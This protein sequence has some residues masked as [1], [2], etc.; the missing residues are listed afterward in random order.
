MANHSTFISTATP[1][2]SRPR[3]PASPTSH[4]ESADEVLTLVRKKAQH[5][6]QFYNSMVLPNGDL[7]QTRYQT[8][9]RSD[10]KRHSGSPDKRESNTSTSSVWSQPTTPV[11]SSS[12]YGGV[13][14]KPRPTTSAKKSI[15]SDIRLSYTLPYRHDEK[16][17]SSSLRSKS[18]SGENFS[19]T[20]PP[21]STSSS[22]SSSD[23]TLL[24]SDF[25]SANDIKQKD[26]LSDEK[27]AASKLNSNKNEYSKNAIRPD[28]PRMHSHLYQV[29]S[30]NKKLNS[31]SNEDKSPTMS[32]SYT[33]P[34]IRHRDE[35][36]A[37]DHSIGEKQTPK[38]QNAPS[39][40][41]QRSNSDARAG[42]RITTNLLS[43]SYD[44]ITD[45]TT[46]G[47]QAGRNYGS[48]SSLDKV[49]ITHENGYS[50]KAR[51]K[52]VYHS[53]P[54]SSLPSSTKHQIKKH[55]SDSKKISPVNSAGSS[56]RTQRRRKEKLRS[57]SDVPDHTVL[58][59]SIKSLERDYSVRQELSFEDEH[60][61]RHR[62]AHYDW[63]SMLF[64]FR[65]VLKAADT[66]K[67]KN[68]TTGASKAAAL[69]ASSDSLGSK[70]SSVGGSSE[71]LSFEQD[72]H[73]DDKSNDMVECCP[74]FSNEVGGE[75]DR[76][77]TIS[78]YGLNSNSHLANVSVQVCNDSE[79]T[80]TQAR[81][82]LTNHTYL[83]IVERGSSESLL[84]PKSPPSGCVS[85]GIEHVDDGAEY[86]RTYFYEKDHQN[87]CG[88]DEKYGPIVISLRREK[89]DETLA[90]SSN[91]VYQ[92]RVIIRTCE[93]CTLRGS[94]V[95]DVVFPSTSKPTKGFH[96]KEVLEYLCPEINLSCLKVAMPIP[97]V[98]DQIM[99]VDEQNVHDSYK[100]GV[101]YCGAGQVTEE[102][103][104]NNEH[105]SPAFDQ[106]LELLGDKIKLSGFNRFRGGLD[107]KTDSTGTE[108]VYTEFRGNKILFHVST[109]LPFTPNNRQQLLRKRHIGND[110][111][112]IIF[113]EP[114][115][116]P[117]NPKFIRS[118]F[119]HVFIIVRV[120]QPCTKDTCYRIAVTR[121]RNIPRFGPPIPEDSMFPNTS[122]FREF[123]LTKLINGENTAHSAGKFKSLAMNTRQEYLR[124]LATTNLTQSGLE[125]NP[126]FSFFAL[127][128]MRDNKDKQK[129]RPMPEVLSHG[130]LT[131][132]LSVDDY[133]SLSSMHEKNQVNCIMGLSD[134]VLT[135]IEISSR[136][137]IFSIPCQAILGWTVPLPTPE[138]IRGIKRDLYI[139]YGRG[140]RISLHTEDIDA[141]DEI[142]IRL[143]KF[144]KGCE[145]VYRQLRRNMKG[146]LGFHVNY[147]GIIMEV[148]QSGYAYQDGLRQ[149]SR[150]VE[151][152]KVAV[153]TMTHE[154]LLD[155]LRTTQHVKVVAIPPNDDGTPRKCSMELYHLY[156]V[157]DVRKVPMPATPVEQQHKS[158]PD[159]S[160][161]IQ[162][163]NDSS[164]K[165]A[166]SEPSTK[167]RGKSKLSKIKQ[168]TTI[169]TKTTL[170]ATATRLAVLNQ[171]HSYKHPKS[172]GNSLSSTTN[173]MS[174]T[175]STSS[176]I[177]SQS[178][179]DIDWS[180]NFKTNQGTSQNPSNSISSDSGLNSNNNSSY[181]STLSCTPTT[182]PI[183]NNTLHELS[184][185]DWDG[186]HSQSHLNQNSS[187]NKMSSNST[188]A[189]S[190]SV[191]TNKCRKAPIK[192]NWNSKSSR[193]P[194]ELSRKSLNHS[195]SVDCT[196]SSEVNHGL[197]VYIAGTDDH[198]KSRSTYSY[199]ATPSPI[200]AETSSR[201]AQHYHSQ[202]YDSVLS[203]PIKW[204]TSVA[205][206]TRSGSRNSPRSKRRASDMHVVASRLKSRD[207]DSP[208]TPESRDVQ[209]SLIKLITVESPT[210]H[211]TNHRKSPARTLSQR[212]SPKQT[213]SPSHNGRLNTTLSI[214]SLHRTVSDESLCAARSSDR[215]RENNLHHSIDSR[216][217]P[218]DTSMLPLPDTSDWDTILDAARAAEVFE[219]SSIRS[220]SMGTLNELGV[221]DD[222][223]KELFR[224]DNRTMSV[225]YLYDHEYRRNQGDPVNLLRKREPPTPS[226][227]PATFH[228]NMT[229]QKSID[230]SSICPDV[231]S[232]AE[233]RLERIEYEMRLLQDK[234]KK[235]QESK[236]ALVEE[237]KLLRRDN[238]R[239]HRDT[240]RV[241]SVKESKHFR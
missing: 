9:V 177:S 124:D 162:T 111:V 149:S 187:N 206:G 34:N 57:K 166:A 130:A 121:A 18:T 42:G 122:T 139:Y 175:K 5:A 95:E 181:S 212:A 12:K 14:L 87:L 160:N 38:R 65:D 119:Q 11:L 184:H 2:T 179:A 62:F 98:H 236:A 44:A 7:P 174:S 180:E 75:I 229:P 80:S 13:W 145:T 30:K 73:I 218:H 150:L 198:I 143:E 223:T 156:P 148:E 36:I 46:I 115:S 125:V 219:A 50:D 192:V 226:S 215:T 109:M 3:G 39:L 213:L 66:L 49:T 76:Q 182:T 120:Y 71:D 20:Y 4:K 96:A 237:V 114:G 106:F 67:R 167:S 35:D 23:G 200:K 78:G 22:R 79:A 85:F 16:Q 196:P 210:K 225:E 230:P 234:L 140:E 228:P 70:A 221:N 45:T 24:S 84:P 102:D 10:V 93:L 29:V 233:Q 231:K 26:I 28:S 108:S 155:L 214:R 61:R 169:D 222:V 51:I 25:S 240:S 207:R 186:L 164:P 69:A 92:Y 188:M 163:A 101:L 47:A 158:R 37:N 193:L 86:Y 204:R 153:A 191:Y 239:L 52:K 195:Y 77:L 157:L 185:S 88:I 97:K 146:E 129:S 32:T 205:M 90:G 203:T 132:Q 176:N 117:F 141:R 63:Q 232:G 54:S 142:I 131:W 137:L 126:K 19:S 241:R 152:C 43:L 135:I 56:P 227:S 33:V 224:S 171:T 31:S 8:S 72:E 197:K 170:V 15:D 94:I 6:R 59:D 118:H 183:A 123:L 82:V 201:N 133:S 189:R 128:R 172:D 48:A 235:E 173:T 58:L 113:Q 154:E 105:G 17:K 144:T 100:I 199:Q 134:C 238:T 165:Q 1:S 103:M 209:N 151:V 21:P 107:V 216:L 74:F 104:Y 40:Q 41:R 68:T 208:S 81:N 110:I 217:N 64:S 99:K 194:T 211:N 127:R 190:T 138:Q 89:L 159:S 83:S 147:E 220:V 136:K 116:Q 202:S 168:A 27:S 112:T 55:H 178:G 91:A 60:R 161:G 53:Q